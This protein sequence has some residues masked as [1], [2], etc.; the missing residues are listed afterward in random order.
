[1]TELQTKPAPP[2][3]GE[4]APRPYRT[5]LYRNGVSQAVRIP[6]ALAFEEDCEVELVRRGDEVIVRPVRKTLG[7]LGVRKAFEAL[8]RS[9][10]GFERIELEDREL[11]WGDRDADGTEA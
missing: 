8:G 5:K 3:S 2:A 1:M 4:D 9:L 6:K 10:V 7:E 11:A